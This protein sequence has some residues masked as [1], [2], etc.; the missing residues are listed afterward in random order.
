MRYLTGPGILD[1][2]FK[3]ARE[4]VSLSDERLIE[5]RMTQIRRINVRSVNVLGKNGAL[6]DGWVAWSQDVNVFPEVVVET[7]FGKVR[8][9]IS[10]T[11]LDN[12]AIA[13]AAGTRGTVRF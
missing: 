13:A 6:A 9:E 2:A 3:A 7:A 5:R 12:L 1:A 4:D 8:N 11:L 10:W